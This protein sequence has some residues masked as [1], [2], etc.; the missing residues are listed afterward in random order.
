MKQREEILITTNRLLA[1][2]LVFSAIQCTIIAFFSSMTVVTISDHAPTIQ[3]LGSI[4]WGDIASDITQRY[5]DMDKDSINNIIKDTKNF[6]VQAKN[7]VSKN[8]AQIFSDLSRTTRKV[9]K[10]VDIL[11][12]VRKMLYDLTPLI[13]K[14][15]SIDLKATID[16][17]HAIIN[18]VDAIHI[19]KFITALTAFLE[20]STNTMSPEVFKELKFIA[21]EFHAFL[22]AE[23]TNLVKNI[24]KDTDDS[25]KNFNRLI[26]AFSRLKK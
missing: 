10:N 9:S 26:D 7:I 14:G 11:D 24:A 17:A 3:K 2:I 6:T 18:K 19:N 21:A 15:N 13:N 22:E 8:G 4:Q 16:K 23:N 20:K 5:L 1:W 25:L 12:I